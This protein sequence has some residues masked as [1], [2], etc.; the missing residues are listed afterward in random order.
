MLKT[1]EIYNIDCLIGIEEMLKQG[2]QADLI[3]TDPP[4]LIRSTKAGGKSD[5]ARSIQPMNDELEDGNLTKGIE[6]VHLKAMWDVMR[7]PNIYIWC[8][9]AQIPQ[10]IDF[11]VNQRNAKW[12]L[13]YGIK[14]TLHRCFAINISRIKSI[15]CISDG[16]H[17]VSRK[18]IT[19]QLPFTNYP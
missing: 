8:N 5:L 4:Y 14:P 17:I 2:L 12:I 13:S 15:V 18:R 1:N 11:F 16:V 10:Y 7:I 3:V 9:G 19:A 6:E